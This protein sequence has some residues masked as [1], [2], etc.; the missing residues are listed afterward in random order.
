MYKKK[1]NVFL[2]LL[3]ALFLLPSSFVTGQTPEQRITFELQNRSLD[4][5]LQELGKISG[6][7]MTYSSQ[8][9]LKYKNVSVEKGVRSVR[10]TLDLLLENT[11]LTA[12]IQN[13]RILIVEK[14][15][16]LGNEIPPSKVILGKVTDEKGEP[17]PGV[18]IR[19]K[20]TSRGTT[21]D[22]EGKFSLESE[23]NEML[24]FYYVG[25]QPLEI[26]AGRIPPVTILSEK[27]EELSEVVITGIYTRSKE[28]FTGSSQT[29]MAK[30]IKAIGNQ[31]IL[32]SLKTL[33][34]SFAVIENNEFGSDPNRLP[35]IEIRGKSSVIGLTEQYGTDP[36]QPLFILD[37]FETTLATISYLSMDRVESITILKDA[38]ATAIYG[39]KAANGVIVVETKRP[40]SGRLKFSYN[41]NTSFNFADL[42]DYNLMNS[43]EKLEYE[44]LTL[45]FGN[46]D[47][48]G[49][50]TSDTGETTYYNRMKEIRRGVDTY[51]LNEPLRF[52]MSHNHNLFIEGGDSNLRYGATLSFGDTQGV[53]Q[54][55]SRKVT[56]GNV[57]LLYRKGRLAFT[58]SLSVD[59]IHA[60][61]EKIAFSA[62][63]RANPYHRKYNETGGIDMI[64]ESFQYLDINTFSTKWMYVYN[65][66][67]DKSNNNMNGTESLGF[68]NNFELEWTVLDGLRA[69]GRI[70]IR[71]SSEQSKVFRSPFNSEFA[72][73][74][75][76]EK[77]SY[78][79]TNTRNNNY[80]GNISLTY[81]KLLDEKHM[82]NAVAGLRFNQVSSA[83]SGYQVVGFVDDDFANPT[84]AFHYPE[85]KKSDFQESKRRSASWYL[86]TG[87]AYDGRY[88]MDATFRTD[89][90]SVYGTSKHFTTTWSTGLAWNIHNESFIKN[91]SIPFNLLK[92]RASIGN[93]GNQNFSDYISM[94]VYRYNQDNRN[95]FGSSV[96]ISNSGNKELKWQ[97]TLDRNIGFDMVVLNNRLRINLDYF[98]KN[99]DPLLVFVSLPSSTGIT[100]MP[101]N[102]GRQV[103]KGF[104]LSSNYALLKK[105][106]LNW[107]VNLNTRRLQSEYRDIDQSLDNFNQQNRSRNL[108]RYYNGGSPSDLWAVKS[109][110]ID[111]A[112]G[113]EVFLNKNDRQT[114]LYNYDDERVVGNSEPDLD[115]IIGTSFFYKGFT[116]SANV[117]Y[118]IGGQ[119]F[120]Q[121][122]YQKVEN[123]TV[124]NILSNHDKRALYDRW[125]NPG[126][127]AKFKAISQTEVTPISS[128]FV[129][130]NNVLSGES[131]SI[132]YETT[133][134]KWMK[135]FG[136]SSLTFRA[137]MNDIFRVSTIKNERG[138]DYPFARSVSFS[139]SARF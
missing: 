34:P 52:A 138:I 77:G 10:E 62:F 21:T 89:G 50:I 97:K 39:S 40:E 96:I 87:Y 74:A 124:E 36:N 31:N 109:L 72:G 114:F 26:M 16:D 108:I 22:S 2:M 17:L 101:Q 127:Q 35:D 112:T 11:N 104:T 12:R 105:D 95:P 122:L 19:I 30:D 64:M 135:T 4:E 99:T 88:L 120:M 90:S 118:R 75:E 43:E 126:D 24:I 14:E 33:D 69:M 9:V 48:N 129:A 106:K 111:P 29:Y 56:D 84:F 125:K 6:F 134:A 78:R 139:L 107:S 115:G 5:G 119:V 93:P 131:I 73:T 85:G 28:S 117:R 15:S 86:N 83:Y 37:G 94:R 59:Y 41:L 18:S 42:S 79:E 58:N 132:G 47:E 113:R 45:Y 63:S 110:G 20:N 25:Y 130:D 81:G 32:Q 23:V 8:L 123:V 136:A 70:G 7:R 102:L 13:S 27:T 91:N 1:R 54:G 3:L 71:Q 80:D 38:S 44:R 92:I 103:T 53:M 61:R 137:Y 121:T 57:K 49:N 65:P 133:D 67:F 82:V 68:T 76:M 98:N 128:R 51:W 46:L 66:L 60:D 116:A 55:S 100:S